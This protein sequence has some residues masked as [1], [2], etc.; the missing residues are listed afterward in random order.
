MSDYT[1]SELEAM[2]VPIP[3]G[4]ET[5]EFDPFVLAQR[6]IAQLLAANKR[7]DEAVKIAEDVIEF[8][9]SIRDDASQSRERLPVE[10]TELTELIDTL[11]PT[12]RRR[13][14]ALKEGASE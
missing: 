3:K 2:A 12:C 10:L 14:R 7:A 9:S 1:R 6:L 13:L 5:F 8:F 4:V 11:L